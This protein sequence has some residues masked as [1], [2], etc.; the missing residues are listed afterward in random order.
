MKNKT[1]FFADYEG[2]S[3]SDRSSGVAFSAHALRKGLA[4]C[5]DGHKQVL[6]R[7]LG[8][9][10]GFVAGTVGSTSPASRYMAPAA[11]PYVTIPYAN[12]NWPGVFQHVPAAEHRRA[13]RAHEQ[14]HVGS[15]EDFNSK[16]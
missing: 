14:L 9:S 3:A 6:W 13:G 10:S 15:G 1:F 11:C 12:A 2:L 8:L 5:P 4:V 7:F 16:T